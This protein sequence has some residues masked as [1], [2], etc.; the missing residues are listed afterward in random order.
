MLI[1]NSLPNIKF[2]NLPY[3][4]EEEL[5]FMWKHFDSSIRNDKSVLRR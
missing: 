4:V 1:L 3:H 2:N 5:Q